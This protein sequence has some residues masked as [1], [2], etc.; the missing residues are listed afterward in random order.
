MSDWA[1]VFLAVWFLGTGAGTAFGILLVRGGSM[2]PAPL[3][4]C[5]GA[6]TRQ[7]AGQQAA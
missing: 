3:P 1:L 2:K 7:Q 5:A 4:D 6:D